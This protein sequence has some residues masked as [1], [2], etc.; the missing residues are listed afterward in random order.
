MNSSDSPTHNSITR[1]GEHN[2]CHPLP[3]LPFRNFCETDRGFG[4]LRAAL[5]VELPGAIE[6][7]SSL[8][9]SA[10]SMLGGCYLSLI[11]LRLAWHYWGT[12]SVRDRL[13]RSLNEKRGLCLPDGAVMVWKFPISNRCYWA[14]GSE[15]NNKQC[16][17]VE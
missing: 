13:R 17:I 15:I 6:S 1:Q 2:A 14:F 12:M 7:M 8:R 3:P 10:A 16:Y 11:S 5:M 4:K 9:V